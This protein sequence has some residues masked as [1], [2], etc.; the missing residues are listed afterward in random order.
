V[1]TI[2]WFVLAFW[3]SEKTTLIAAVVLY[4]VGYG[5]SA[6]IGPTFFSEVFGIK[7]YG[8][9]IG[10]LAL[11]VGCKYEGKRK[12]GEGEEEGEGEV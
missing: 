12:E 9:N 2:A 6:S 11:A 1:S 7:N 10:I 3:M 4:G 8:K 5:T